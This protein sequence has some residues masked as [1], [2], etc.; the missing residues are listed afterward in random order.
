MFKSPVDVDL[1]N[2]YEVP[3]VK[4]L[5]TEQII[6]IL[7]PSHKDG[8]EW[9]FHEVPEHY[10]IDFRF[11][12]NFS[13]EGAGL[14]K[15]GCSEVFYKRFK[16]VRESFDS[17]SFKG[18]SAFF[19][20]DRWYRKRGNDTL[21]DNQCSHRGLQV[22]NKCGTCPGHGL[23]WDKSTGRLKEVELPFFLELANGE[24]V[25]KDNPRGVII[26]DSCEIRIFSPFDHDGTII[27]VDATGERY[28]LAKQSIAPRSYRGDESVVFDVKSLC[29]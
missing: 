10:H 26:S 25:H 2:E 6:P 22:V 16:V 12:N 9:C 14:V 29:K 5:H 13:F 20:I 7:L 17:L 21:V 28:G 23:I 4:N 8:N 15:S 3:C 1:D 19:F 18:E 24:I 11:Y 27:M